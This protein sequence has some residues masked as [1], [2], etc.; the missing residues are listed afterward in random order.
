MRDNK[1]R[2]VVLT[3]GALL[4][5]ATLVN[6]CSEHAKMQALEVKQEQIAKQEKAKQVKLAKQEEE[7]KAEIAAYLH[8]VEYEAGSGESGIYNSCEYRFGKNSQVCIDAEIIRRPFIKAYE[9]LSQYPGWL[10]SAGGKGES[11]ADPN[12]CLEFYSE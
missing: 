7:K 5:I 4:T 8:M 6:S 3:I 12:E 1:V 2:T 10:C 11:F 9:E